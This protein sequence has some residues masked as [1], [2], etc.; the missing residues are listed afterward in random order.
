[1]SSLLVP[2]A[3]VLFKELILPV[4]ESLLDLVGLIN[5]DL[6]IVLEVVVVVNQTNRRLTIKRIITVQLT[7]TRRIVLRVVIVA[8]NFRLGDEACRFQIKIN[9][10][11]VAL[12]ECFLD[13]SWLINGG[14]GVNG[15]T[16]G[17]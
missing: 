1:M 9:R 15:E 7:V 12:Y 4:I 6:D 16:I 8:S 17:F 11:I 5:V 10:I 3:V 13:D 14:L 2:L